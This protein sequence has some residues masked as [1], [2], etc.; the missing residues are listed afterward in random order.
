MNDLPTGGGMM[1]VIG[2]I[3]GFIPFLEQYANNVQIAAYNTKTQIV[4]A[5]NTNTLDQL[6]LKAR[7]FNL[8]TQMLD[9][10]HGFHSVLMEPM[11]EEF[12]AC[13][14]G[15]PAREPSLPFF[16]NLTGTEVSSQVDSSY[17]IRHVR[18]AVRFI[19][20]MQALE[21]KEINFFMEIGP[22]PVLLGFAGQIFEKPFAGVASL[23]PKLHDFQTYCEGLKTLYL[24]DFDVDWNQFYKGYNFSFTDLPFYP[25][26]HQSYW[27]DSLKKH[28][29]E[30]A[31]LPKELDKS[32]SPSVEVAP[33]VAEAHDLINEARI[34]ER[35]IHSLR[36]T[37]GF[38]ETDPIDEEKNF[39]DIG[40]DSLMAIQFKNLLQAELVLYRPD[41]TL[42]NTLIFNYPTIQKV[43]TYIGELLQEQVKTLPAK[44]SIAASDEG[45][46]A[47]IGM[48]C[49]FPGESDTPE[50]FWELLMLKKDG[51]IE[52]PDSRSYYKSYCYP[53]QHEQAKIASL[54]G[55]DF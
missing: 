49:R 13:F 39:L 12:S 54:W 27:A 5:G 33:A 37:M 43:C 29:E 4:L 26:D 36:K 18:E 40:I 51:V 30:Q 17:W 9:V 24:H 41:I 52:V 25:F 6:G 44:D 48:A 42:P 3:Q 35:V 34:K 7:N 1:V 11:M 20:G 21:E 14:E 46:I 28:L 47:V 32:F 15:I 2:N 45:S 55:G 22:R 38:R 8:T 23:N 50:D 10:S 31:P 16:S 19:Q 53:S